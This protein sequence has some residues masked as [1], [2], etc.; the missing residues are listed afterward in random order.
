MK[1][2][3]AELLETWP[4]KECNV[5]KGTDGTVF[6]PLLKKEEGIV[7]FSPDLCR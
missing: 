2:N 3:D 5:F 4:T 7:S 1:F 6:P